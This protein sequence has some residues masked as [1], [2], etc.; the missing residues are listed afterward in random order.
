MSL[1]DKL[2][3]AKE[4][5]LAANLQA[6]LDFLAK[7]KNEEGVV[8]LE[9]GLQYKVLKREQAISPGQQIQ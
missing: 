1:F 9:S 5:K 8:E 3:K 4:E 6:G 2:N 7:N